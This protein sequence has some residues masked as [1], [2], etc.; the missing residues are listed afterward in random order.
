[1]GEGTRDDEGVVAGVLALEN[2][3]A[4]CTPPGNDLSGSVLASREGEYSEF[5]SFDEGGEGSVPG[6]EDE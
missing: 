6:S 5:S 4:G 2:T 1:V 3:I